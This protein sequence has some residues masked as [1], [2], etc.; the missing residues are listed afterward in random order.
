MVFIKSGKAWMRD[1][2]TNLVQSLSIHPENHVKL[3]QA[4]FG[5]VTTEVVDA[6][7]FYFAEDYHQQYLHKNPGGYCGIG[8]TGVSCPIG[9]EVD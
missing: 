4:G 2:G 9:L 8:G 6:P 7:V 5:E 1:A 3:K